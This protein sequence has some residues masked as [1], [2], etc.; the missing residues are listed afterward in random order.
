MVLPNEA[1]PVK[2]VFP[3]LTNKLK[4]VKIPMRYVADRALAAASTRASSVSDCH[5]WKTE[6]NALV[7]LLMYNQEKAILEARYTAAAPFSNFGSRRAM[8]PA[9]GNPLV[10][11]CGRLGKSLTDGGSKDGEVDKVVVVGSLC[12]EVFGLHGRG[13]FRIFN[14]C[15]V[16]LWCLRQN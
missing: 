3:A 14:A 13:E 1:Y 8:L 16:L 11:L 12:S 6:H 4:Q 15:D 10:T 5:Q 7:V 2:K 9:T